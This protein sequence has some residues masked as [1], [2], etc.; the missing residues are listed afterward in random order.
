MEVPNVDIRV[1]ILGGGFAGVAAARTLSDLPVRVTLVDR[2]NHHLFKPLL[3]QVASGLL[4]APDISV[5]LRKL[6]V[7]QKNVTVLMDEVTRVA[8]DERRVYLRHTALNYDYLVIATG[9]THNYFGRDDWAPYAPGLCTIG[10]ALDVRRRILRAFEAAELADSSERQS[11]WTTFV[12]VGGGPTGVEL[13]GAIAEMRRHTLA[14]E[15]RRIDSRDA[16][17][18]LLEAGPRL[19]PT[20]SEQ[21]SADA[22][23]QLEALGVEVLTAAAVTAVDA[24]GVQ[25][26]DVHIP[27]R[28]VLWA[29][30]VRASSLTTQLGVPLERLGR[31]CLEDDLSLPG[32]PEVF[33]AGDLI[34]RQRGGASLPAVA[35]LALQS[36]RHA[37]ACIDADMRGRP[38][39]SFRYR[40]RGMLATIGRNRAI[41][42]LEGFRFAGRLAWLL[43]LVI[44]LLTLIER[45]RRVSVLWEWAW[46]Y[47]AGQRGCRLIV[48]QPL[49]PPARGA[50]QLDARAS[51]EMR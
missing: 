25:V 45:R 18:V 50:E 23:R 4:P 12:V 6:F 26:G 21:S 51:G 10:E 38:R 35:P 19:L 40:H 2:S 37:A 15:F 29:A 30:G 34:A 49:H 43:W 46:S 17:V 32:R 33:L 3:Y 48:D 8:L 13:A 5:P 36:G 41:A 22:Q 31:V 47:F 16:R 42:Q 9:S 24:E 20:F 39:A 28:T 1:L 27:S 11:A 44:H 14:G 7:H